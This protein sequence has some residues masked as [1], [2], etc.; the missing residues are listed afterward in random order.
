MKP[1]WGGLRVGRR[2]QPAWDEAVVRML[3][4]WQRLHQGQLAR[5]R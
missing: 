4:A 1:V 5:R 2:P 3:T